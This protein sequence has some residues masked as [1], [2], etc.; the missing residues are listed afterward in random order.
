VQ[1]SRSKLVSAGGQPDVTIDALITQAEQDQSAAAARV[2]SADQQM[3]ALHQKANDL[4]DAV[5]NAGNDCLR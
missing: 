5:Q 4:Y 1:G 3:K 2:T